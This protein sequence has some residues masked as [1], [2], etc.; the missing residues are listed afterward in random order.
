MDE[1]RINKA[2]FLADFY[3]NSVNWCTN[4]YSICSLLDFEDKYDSLEPIDLNEFSKK[5]ET[6]AENQW[7]LNV[8][9][10]PKLMTYKLFTTTLAPEKYCTLHTN[11][12]KCSVFA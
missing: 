1:D 12:A 8:Q 6:Y 4:S 2:I 9:S 7:K 11:R 3:A 10:K 5:M